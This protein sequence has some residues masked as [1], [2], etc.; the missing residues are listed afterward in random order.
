MAVTIGCH[1][2]SLLLAGLRAA[3]AACAACIACDD[4]CGEPEQQRIV[5]RRDGGLRLHDQGY[6]VIGLGLGW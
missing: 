5:P 4:G 1:S 6:K 2:G 3:C